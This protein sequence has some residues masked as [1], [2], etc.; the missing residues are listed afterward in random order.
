M[1]VVM[2]IGY[3][4]WSFEMNWFLVMN[5]SHYF[6]RLNVSLNWFGVVNL[7]FLFWL[8][9]MNG[10][11]LMVSFWHVFVLF[12]V[13]NISRM[14]FNVNDWL[15]VMCRFVMHLNVLL[16]G[17]FMGNVYGRIVVFGDWVNMMNW[18][19]VFH[20]LF[21]MCNIFVVN[22]A[23][24]LLGWL[25]VVRL[26]N[27]DWLYLMDFSLMSSHFVLNLIYNVDLTLRILFVSVIVDWMFF[28]FGIVEIYVHVVF[29][30]VN[31]WLC[32]W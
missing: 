9:S 14:L 21:N 19:D 30:V 31:A 22:V 32:K 6:W 10:F 17:L 16:D 13:L 26:R 3:C 27:F 25:F 28:F 15:I 5:F 18:L 1:S 29:F 23:Y 20:L 11:G 24:V 4:F 7:R 8:F 2:D 12:D